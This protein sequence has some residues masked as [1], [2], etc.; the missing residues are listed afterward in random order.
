MPEV[1]VDR[2]KAVLRPLVRHRTLIERA[3]YL[4]TPILDPQTGNDY[5]A[6]LLL[7]GMPSAIGKMGASELGGLRRF[8]SK[9][10]SDGVC[11]SWGWHRLRLNV[12]AGVYP[13]DDFTLSRFCPAYSR[14]LGD[15]DLLAAWY[16]HG[17][18]RLV[19]RFAPKA[20]L[21]SLTALEPFYHE[22]PWSRHLKGKRVL[23]ISPFA[24][25]IEEQ[26]KRRADIWRNNPEVLPE[27]ALE[28]LRCP[29]SAALVKP[30]FTDWF[31]A[32]EAMQNEMDRRQYDALLV[33][34]GAWSLALVAHAKS[35]GKWAIHLGGGTQLLF[36]IRGG[37]WD[38]NNFLQTMYNA[39]WVRPGPSD[40]PDAVHKIENGCYW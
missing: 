2:M 1:L 9:K 25:I 33:G 11:R 23:V 34:A 30:V 7:R 15:L 16:H 10:R 35:R 17:E 40:R 19:S 6:D 20:T 37:R 38:D 5:I 13:D 21:V 22:R 18:R 39:A 8:E 28:T 27:F 26:Y 24:A 14:A 3:K 36:G 29:L 12:N 4:G 32:L 31:E